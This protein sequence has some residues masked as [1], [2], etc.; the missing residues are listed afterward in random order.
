[1]RKTV[2]KL[3][4]SLD[5]VVASTP[6]CALEQINHR[7]GWNLFPERLEGPKSLAC[8]FFTLTPLIFICFSL[9]GTGLADLIKEA[10]ERRLDN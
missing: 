1:M 7:V 8:V 5:E 4:R 3:G 10:R 2:S 9:W 6:R